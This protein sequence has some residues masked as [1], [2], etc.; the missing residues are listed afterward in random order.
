M[1]DSPRGAAR[2]AARG[3]DRA[4]HT[5]AAAVRERTLAGLDRPPS[6]AIFSQMAEEIHATCPDVTRL[7]CFRLARGWT[8]EEAIAQFHRM[9]DREGLRR[10]GLTER[11]W[12]EWEAGARPDRDYTDLLCRLFETG[13]VQLG[14]ARDYTPVDGRPLLSVDPVAAVAA[15]D[16]R[17]RRARR[18]ERDRPGHAGAAAHRD[19]V[20]LP[21]VRRGRPAAAVRGDAAA[22]GARPP[23]AGAAHPPA[24]GDRAVLPHRRAERAHGEREHGHGPARARRPA[25]PGR[26]HLRADRRAHLADGLGARHAG[27]GRAVGPP[28]RRRGGVRRGRGEPPALRVGRRPA[29]PAARPRAGDARP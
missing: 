21:P 26:L 25:R 15:G 24:A 1:S 17:A 5:V 18:G 22:A 8:V 3:R 9:C 13:P 4:V 20:G 10:R 23:G 2:G 16:E 27:L 7:K 29:A 6:P 28:V 19:G 14:F 11:S 12:R